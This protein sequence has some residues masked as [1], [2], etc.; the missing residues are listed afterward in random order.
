MQVGGHVAEVKT[1]IY[2][3]FFCYRQRIDGRW[4]WVAKTTLVKGEAVIISP[5]G[6]EQGSDQ[7]IALAAVNDLLW[8]YAMGMQL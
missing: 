6:Q 4:K 3:L 8:I 2:V 1:R 5:T 7:G